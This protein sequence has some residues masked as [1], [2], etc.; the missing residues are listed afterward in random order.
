MRKT[1]IGLLILLLGC[2]SLSWAQATARSAASTEMSLKDLETKWAAAFQKADAAAIGDI[3]A[4]DFVSI[5][6][7]GKIMSKADVLSEAK[8]SKITKSAV[9]DMRVRML[10]NEAAIV[11]G[12]WTGAGTDPS[13]KKF[14]TSSR[15]TDVFVY[16]NGKWKCV[17]SQSTTTKK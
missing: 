3:L 2:A 5:N 12:V 9:S 15:W 1:S 14:D 17:A 6:A 4:D 10:S 13:G 7:E 11:S 8:K 16:K